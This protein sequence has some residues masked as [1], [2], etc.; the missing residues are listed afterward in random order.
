MPGITNFAGLSDPGGTVV[1]P[2][3]TEDFILQEDGFFI[4]QEDGSKIIQ[5]S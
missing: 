2:P 1:P 3:V 5:E 4:L